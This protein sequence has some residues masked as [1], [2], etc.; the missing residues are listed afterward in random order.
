MA[1]VAYELGTPVSYERGTP[2]WPQA[3]HSANQ[4]SVVAMLA[5]IRNKRSTGVPRQL[6]NAHPPRT[7]GIGQL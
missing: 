6:E 4:G 3:S 1:S 2:S 5:L 7:L